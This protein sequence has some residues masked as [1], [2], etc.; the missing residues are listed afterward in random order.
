MRELAMGPAFWVVVAVLA[1]MA[2]ALTLVHPAAAGSV[3]FLVVAVGLFMSRP[4]LMAG[5]TYAGLML[6]FSSTTGISIGIIPV[7]LPKIFVLLWIAG[8]LVRRL[9]SHKPILYWSPVS[10]G[11]LAVFLAMVLSL[12]FNGVGDQ[13]SF[14]V[15][16]FLLVAT[17]GQLTFSSVRKEHV[18]ASLW[19]MGVFFVGVVMWSLLAGNYAGDRSLGTFVNANRW[20]AVM[21]VMLPIFIGTFLTGG[22]I[23]S[24]VFIFALLATVPLAVA[25]TGSRGGLVSVGLTFP[26]LVY[27]LRKRPMVLGLG[28]LVGAGVMLWV[29]LTTT[30]L[31]ERFSVLGESEAFESDFSFSFRVTVL[32]VALQ[33]FLD[34][35]L[36]GIGVG[37]FLEQYALSEPSTLYVLGGT[38]TA[39]NQFGL[40]LAEQGILGLGALGYLVLGHLRNLWRAMREDRPE[41]EKTLILAFMAGLV[42]AISQGM[43]LESFEYPVFHLI[44]AL[45]VVLIADPEG[46][47][48]TIRSRRVL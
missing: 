35:P 18:R 1:V 22:P 33:S 20:A 40:T 42:A 44:F 26:V 43:F 23:V 5:L 32:Q 41:W 13:T 38:K 28:A 27:L 37:H 3:F 10:S 12:V 48:E 9:V 21:V 25:Q 4:W 47:P 8:W 7:T 19:L 30:L 2:G 34:K 17:M 31:E 36:I 16:S 45:S 39:H 46:S 15:V 11:Y 6:E 24:R 14:A 29:V